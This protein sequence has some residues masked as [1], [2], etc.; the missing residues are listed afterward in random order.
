MA[1][2]LSAVN[3]RIKK[4][5]YEAQGITAFAGQTFAKT[6]TPPFYWRD[7]YEQ[8]H[9]LGIGSVYLCVFTGVF[10]GQALA[11]QFSKEM[12]EFGA[13]DYMGRIVTL[14]NVRALGPVLTG[15]MVAARVSS[16]IAA[17]IGAMKSSNQIDALVSFGTDPIK[18]LAVP[19]LLALFLMMPILTIITDAISI[20]GGWIVS[21]YIVHV[22]DALYWTNV[23]QRLLF[24]N[25]LVGL[26]KPFVFGVIIAIVGCYK[27]FASEGGTRGVGRATREAVV[28]ASISI[29]VAEFMMTKGLFSLLGW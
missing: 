15:L 2:V 24:G 25:L 28:I 12:A 16:G 10:A 4:T 8:I 27:G 6:F 22:S 1:Q 13:K 7:L 3:A 17:E 5:V 19:R 23:K 11:L 9:F 29:L 18:K 14:A 21:H 20:I 26:T